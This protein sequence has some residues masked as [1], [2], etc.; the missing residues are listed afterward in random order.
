[1]GSR[2]GDRVLLV[3][4][5]ENGKLV[6]GALNLIGGD[7]LFGRNWGCSNEAHYHALHFEACYY[8]VLLLHIFSFLHLWWGH[9]CRWICMLGWELSVNVSTAHWISGRRLRQQLSGG[10]RQ[11]K[12]G[13]RVSTRFSEATCLQRLTVHIIFQIL[14]SGML[15][16]VSCNVKLY[17]LGSVLWACRKTSDTYL[18]HIISSRWLWQFDDDAYL[19]CSLWCFCRQ[20]WHCNCWVTQAP[21]RKKLCKCTIQEATVSNET[22][23][24]LALVLQTSKE[25]KE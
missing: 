3:I 24:L 13:H 2:M 9:S 12:Q 7:T 22:Q 4:A 14:T 21:S 25:V 19:I 15:S 17:K 10:S 5:E 18:F 1:M 6:A 20:R 11:W 16:P 23:F 8:Q